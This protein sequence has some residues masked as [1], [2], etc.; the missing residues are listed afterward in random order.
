MVLCT[1]LHV[2]ALGGRFCSEASSPLFLRILR[3]A[4]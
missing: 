3:D 2:L 4:Y 1:Y